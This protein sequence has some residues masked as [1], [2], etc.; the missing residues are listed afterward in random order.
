[1]NFLVVFIIAAL[2]GG[3]SYSSTTT[4]ADSDA[5]ALIGETLTPTPLPVSEQT[6]DEKKRFSESISGIKGLMGL[7]EGFDR[8]DDLMRFYNDDG[9]LWYEFTF[10]Y[11]DSDGH[12][13]YENDNFRPYLFQPDYFT[14]ALKITG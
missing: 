14:L 10:Y 3:C 7:N 4:Q 13:E 12:F 8:L 6:N 1:M 2:L 9:T 11:D 5:K